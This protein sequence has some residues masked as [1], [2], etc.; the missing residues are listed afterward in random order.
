MLRWSQ[1]SAPP[2]GPPLRNARIG[3]PRRTSSDRAASPGRSGSC[4]RP[5]RRATR[6]AARR[7]D[8]AGCSNEVVCCTISASTG[9]T[10]E[11]PTSQSSDSVWAAR[12]TAGCRRGHA[13]VGGGEQLRQR[14]AIDAGAL[15]ELGL[16]QPRPTNR[17]GEAFAQHDG[18]AMRSGIICIVDTS[19]LRQ[20]IKRPD[21]QLGTSESPMR[22]QLRTARSRRV[23]WPTLVV[24]VA[25][26]AGF[27]AVLAWHGRLPLG[28][29]IAALAILGAWYNSLQHEVVHGHPTPWPRFNAALAV[30]PLGLVVSF[31]TYRSSHLAH[32]RTPELTDPDVDP[33]SFYVSMRT[34]SGAAAF[35]GRRWWRCRPSPGGCCSAR[36]WRRCGGCASSWRRRAAAVARPVCSATASASLRCWPSCGRAGWRGGSM[37]PVSVGAAGR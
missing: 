7:R 3:S 12:S 24:A 4:T 15:G 18:G 30:I 8:R 10:S 6:A 1:S 17:F 16:A 21:A 33:E 5:L 25:I 11:S 2:A 32:H 23:E 35:A 37:P 26:A 13:L 14:R 9:P 22:T 27:A 29:V 34:W 36:S 20:S 19:K 31:A 28:L